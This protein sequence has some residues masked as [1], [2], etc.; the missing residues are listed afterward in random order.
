MYLMTKL[1][2]LTF[3]LPKTAANI[4]GK[5]QSV[6]LSKEKKG[7]MVQWVFTVVFSHCH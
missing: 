1:A 3:S 7:A 2:C 6:V 5:L 4:M